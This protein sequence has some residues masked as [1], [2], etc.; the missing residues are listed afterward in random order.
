M[1]VRK[2]P[3][4]VN[5]I[6]HIVNRGIASQPIFRNARDYK[7]FIETFL[8]YQNK[9]VPLKFSTF[10]KL[11]GK[12]KNDV[13]QKLKKERNFLVEIIAFCLMPNHIHF[14]IRQSEDN[15][16][17][18]FMRN[19]MNSYCRYFNLKSERFGPLFQGRFKAIRIETPEQLLHVSRYIH[20]NP[21]SGLVVKTLDQLISYPYSSLIEYLDAGNIPNPIC[22]KEIILE[23]F[24][25]SSYKD[26]VFDQADY[27]RELQRIK[28][29]VLE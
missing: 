7:R 15:G 21:F 23:N 17:S 28:H 6:Y 8:Y 1:P 25:G 14:L 5:E 27:Q 19:T 22:N 20:L 29:L 16:I 26:F 24:E 4:A 10:T 18:E 11:S 3:L 9:K 13:L 2:I 12:E